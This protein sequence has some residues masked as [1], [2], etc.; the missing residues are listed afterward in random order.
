MARE[1]S[2]RRAAV[3]GAA[4]AAVFGLLVGVGYARLA[5]HPPAGRAF[6]PALWFQDDVYQHL[7]FA[8]Q[9]SRGH[10]LLGNK[11]DPRK[12]VALL[13][14]PTWAA[15]GLAGRAVGNLVVGMHLVALLSVVALGA[16][17]GRWL[18]RAGL[19][20]RALTWAILL[21]FTG[22]GLGWLQLLISGQ[23]GPSSPDLSMAVFP[24]FH[25]LNASA[26][27]C[28][29]L[30]MLVWSLQLLLDWRS[31]QGRAWT[32]IAVAALL[33]L[34]RPFDLV[35]FALVALSLAGRDALRGEGREAMR[36][37]GTLAWL[38]PVVL[39]DGLV[40]FLHPS[41][42]LWTGPQNFVPG[43]SW[44]GLA[45][46]LGPA[47]LAASWPRRGTAPEP[48][49]A[50]AAS[51]RWV[52]AVWAGLAVISLVPGPLAF[53]SQFANAAGAALLL[54]AAARLPPKALPWAVVALLPS[55]L[56]N[57]ARLAWPPESW[58]PPRDYAEAVRALA[59][60]C[61][62]GEFVYGPSDPSLMIA[63]G[64]PCGAI[65]GHRVL[66]PDFSQRAAESEIFYNPHTT[67]AWRR[68]YLARMGARFVLIPRRSGD[69]LGSAPGLERYLQTPLLEVWGPP[70]A[71]NH[72]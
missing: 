71:P 12:H 50:F 55:T 61:E 59:Q 20:G 28:A 15:M 5:A 44:S 52:F 13:V 19:R 21:F 16:G 11:F 31:G 10:L 62:P 45:W 70:P 35:L 6:P 8:E 46:G 51:S 66:T 47:V 17:V 42:S 14:N 37:A 25:V 4:V 58:F 54:S 63:A 27:A 56:V 34:S 67:A 1:L 23:D 7:S 3:R 49:D 43:P 24:S 65:F 9:A 57:G 18:H 68:E 33:G 60:R 64:T 30:A 39:Y 40:Y 41:F 36:L 26:H 72:R 2:A 53:A 69:W 22:G 48:E 32:W 38:G 29:A